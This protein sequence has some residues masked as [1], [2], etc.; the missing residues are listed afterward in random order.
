MSPVLGQ[1]NMND[2]MTAFSAEHDAHSCLSSKLGIFP[3]SASGRRCV[4]GTVPA[5]L[6]GQESL[7]AL[8]LGRVARPLKKLAIMPNRLL[9]YEVFHWL[10][11]LRQAVTTRQAHIAIK[12]AENATAEART[13]SSPSLNV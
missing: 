7:D 3:V 2:V 6:F 13:S 1:R 10:R 9:L 11:M 4:R 12:A 5:L 8:A